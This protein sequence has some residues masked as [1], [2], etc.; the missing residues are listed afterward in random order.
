MNGVARKQRWQYFLQSFLD[1][2]LS[3]FFQQELVKTVLDFDALN[4]DNVYIVN[5]AFDDDLLKIKSK[6]DSLKS[7]IEA[8]ASKMA[9]TLGLDKKSL[10]LDQSAQ[11]GYCFR[12]TMKDEQALRCVIVCGHQPKTK[13]WGM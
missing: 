2:H 9:S 5:A 11:H 10:K 6:M 12:V 8:A 7:D 4:N 3:A 13:E 1:R